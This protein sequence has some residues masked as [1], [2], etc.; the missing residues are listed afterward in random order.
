[1]NKLLQ[2]LGF[3]RRGG[4]HERAAPA[5]DQRPNAEQDAADL[6]AESLRKDDRRL[7]ERD[8]FPTRPNYE[9]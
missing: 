8:E 1:M 3:G 5:P 4:K 6:R 9:P 7:E 2:M